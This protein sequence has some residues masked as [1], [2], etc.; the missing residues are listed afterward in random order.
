MM[1]QADLAQLAAD[2]PSVATVLAVSGLII[3]LLLV[4]FGNKL[5]RTAH[6]ITGLI[7]G[8]MLGFVLSNG[9]DENGVWIAWSIGG[10]AIGL[11]LSLVLFR[12]WVGVSLAIVLG[13]MMPVLVLLWSH[14]S[15][16]ATVD[17]AGDDTVQSLRDATRDAANPLTRE[18]VQLPELTEEMKEK[19]AALPAAQWQAVT[20]WWTDLADSDRQAA[21]LALGAGLVLGLIFGLIK[22]HLGAALQA[23]LVGAVLLTLSGQ[24]VLTLFLDEESN[25]PR[26]P[27]VFVLAV[28]LI[29]ILGVLVQWTILRG[30]AD[31]PRR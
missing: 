31:R 14:T 24:H 8:A 6:A 12:L 13:V 21:L 10:A 22:P 19:L 7:V 28:G 27:R 15:P 25:L 29:T 26:G 20:E 5:V 11:V 17:V 16:P 3:G 23:A 2:L 4:L 1:E 30:K 18:D 9:F